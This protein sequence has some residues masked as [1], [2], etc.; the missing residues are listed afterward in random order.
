[1]SRKTSTNKQLMQIAAGA[2]RRAAQFIS[3]TAPPPSNEWDHK[4]RSDFATWVDREAEKIIADILLAA[5]PDSTVMGEELSP[6]TTNSRLSWVVDPL[7]GTTNYLHGFP[8]YAV[9]IA[10]VAGG[11]IVAGALDGRKLLRR[12]REEARGPAAPGYMFPETS[13]LPFPLSGPGFLSRFLKNCPPTP[14]NWR[15]SSGRRRESAALAPQPW[16]WRT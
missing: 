12:L 13:N 5:E 1:M 9:S 6:E 4:G 8:G 7:D 11:E 2:A 14:T 10:A 3:S 16:T 15:G